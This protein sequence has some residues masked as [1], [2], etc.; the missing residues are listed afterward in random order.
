MY[1]VEMQRKT[2]YA[3]WRVINLPAEV[4]RVF[5]KHAQAGVFPDKL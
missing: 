4:T 5:L 3:Y 2:L 1:S